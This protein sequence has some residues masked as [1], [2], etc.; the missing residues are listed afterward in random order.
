MEKEN[1]ELYNELFLLALSQLERGDRSS[2]IELMLRQKCEDIVLITVVLKEARNA[3]YAI[4]R[5]EGFRLILAGCC[6]GL[7][8]FLITLF[9]FNT[10]R[11]IDVAMYGLTTAGLAIVFRG[12]FKVIG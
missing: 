1:K 9:N 5:R 8:G 3:H 11:S 4:L 2:N 10:S 7:G 6:I 12:L